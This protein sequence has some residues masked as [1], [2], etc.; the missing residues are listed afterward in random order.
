[1]IRGFRSIHPFVLFVY[2]VYIITSLMLYQHPFFLLTA[3]CLVVYVH[4][5][6]DR[7]EQL[8]RWIWMLV[9]MSIFIFILTP[10]FNRRGNH[11]LFYLFDN[12]VMLEAVIQGVMIALTLMCILAVFITFNIVMTSDKFLFIVS[13]WF[14][15]WG[16]LIMLSMRFVPLLRKRLQDIEQVQQVKGVSLRQGTVRQ[17]AK[18]GMLLM[19]ILLTFS[20]EESIQSGDS[21]TARGYGLQKRSKYHPYEMTHR[22]WALGFVMTVFFGIILY[23]WWLEDGVLA[24]LP[25]LEPIWLSGREWFFYAI[26]FMFIGIPIF[27]EGR[28]VLKWKYYQQKM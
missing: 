28:E 15:K 22:D 7:G 20:L 25:A 18:N 3:L 14:P 10:F 8:K 11:V 26:W 2:Y 27:V 24:L 4:V 6:L 13:K 9:L 21:M 16:M 1:M 19:Q 17:R 12:P 23:G 5:L